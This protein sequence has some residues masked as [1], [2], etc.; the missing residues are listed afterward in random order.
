MVGGMNLPHSLGV[1]RSKLVPVSMK[2]RGAGGGGLDLI[3]GLFLEISTTD[4]SGNIR[5]SRQMC[6]IAHGVEKVLLSREACKDLGVIKKNFPDV[7]VKEAKIAQS[8]HQ[9]P[10]SSTERIIVNKCEQVDPSSP[11]QCSCPRRTSPPP[12]R[13]VVVPKKNGKPRRCVDFQQL[14]KASVRQT[15]PV[16]TPFH[17]AMSIPPNTWRSCLNAMKAFIAFPSEKRT[18][19]SQLLSLNMADIA[20]DAY[21]RDF[22]L[23]LTVTLTGLTISQ[24]SCT[25]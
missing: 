15:H 19:T 14:N 12:S 6:Y 5:I 24:D 18:D 16:K 17:Q 2:L 4:S 25:Y 1:K 3:G 10:K 9:E 11:D 8:E 22:Y 7:G 13:M 21:L 23:Q 20:T